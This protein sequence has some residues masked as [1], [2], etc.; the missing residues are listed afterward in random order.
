MWRAQRNFHHFPV[1]FNH[2]YTES[3][4]PC[5]TA[6]ARGPTW[7]TLSVHVCG[8]DSQKTG[9]TEREDKVKE[10]KV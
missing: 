7:I 5:C 6:W 1:S 4:A 9:E 10:K 2:S 3:S 8:T